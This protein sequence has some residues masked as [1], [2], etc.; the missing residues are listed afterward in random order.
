M[1]PNRSGPDRS[2][3]DNQLCFALYA[4]SNAITRLYRPLLNELGLTY[5]QYLVILVLAEEGRST[6]GRIARRLDLAANAITPLLDRMDASGLVRR[7]RDGTDRRRVHVEL[8]ERGM[9][10]EASF[11][12][13]QQAVACGTG[14][15][16]DQI[17]TLRG[18]LRALAERA[19]G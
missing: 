6:A 3:L 17:A 12:A 13:V 1:P 5:P 8:T 16:D 14:L 18:E 9:E 2:N 15:D 4:A 10:V 7:G 19:G 11:G